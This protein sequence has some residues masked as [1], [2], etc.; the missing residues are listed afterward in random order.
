MDSSSTLAIKDWE[1]HP[2]TP[3]KSGLKRIVSYSDGDEIAATTAAGFS[4]AL[5]PAAT[6]PGTLSAP[7]LAA[8]SLSATAPA[9]MAPLAEADDPPTV[10][11][12]TSAG[13][14]TEGPAG[15]VAVGVAEV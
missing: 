6:A 7:A 8:E 5:A 14:V 3:I 10:E 13:G 9:A 1:I 15:G 4:P 12:F 11:T 2:L